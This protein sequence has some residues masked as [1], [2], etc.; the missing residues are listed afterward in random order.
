[1]QHKLHFYSLKR[2]PFY[3]VTIITFASSRGQTYLQHHTID[4]FDNWTFRELLTISMHRTLTLI[5]NGNPIILEN[6]K[7]LQFLSSFVY[8]QGLKHV[9]Y[10]VHRKQILASQVVVKWHFYCLSYRAFRMCSICCFITVWIGS[11]N[12]SFQ[13]TIW[14]R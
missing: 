8:L 9:A 12:W 5:R 14:R 11:G 13:R 4:E 7:E 1:M 6:K 2:I 10:I 3:H